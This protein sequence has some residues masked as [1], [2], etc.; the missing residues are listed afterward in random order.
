MAG[1]IGRSVAHFVGG[2]DGAGDRMHDDHFSIRDDDVS[3][4]YCPGGSGARIVKL[5][6]IFGH[7]GLEWMVRGCSVVVLALHRG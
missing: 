6:V 3:W 5:L 2:G 1:E 7:Y 4:T